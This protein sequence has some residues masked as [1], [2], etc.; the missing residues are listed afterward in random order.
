VVFIYRGLMQNEDN[1]W[2]CLG[3]SLHVSS[4]SRKIME[5]VMELFAC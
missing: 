2:R 4:L 5:I 3:L 1:G